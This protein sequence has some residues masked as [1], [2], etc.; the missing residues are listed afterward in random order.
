MRSAG[1][2][3][4]VWLALFWTALGVGEMRAEGGLTA[5][6]WGRDDSGQLGLGTKVVFETPTV[7]PQTGALAGKTIIKTVA[8]DRH[9]LALTADQKVFA[10]GDNQGGQL[11]NPDLLPSSVPTEVPFPE[12]LVGKTVIDLAVTLSASFLLTADFELWGWGGMAFGVAINRPQATPQRIDGGVLSGKSVVKIACGAAH[13]LALTADGMVAGV[14]VNSSGQ[15]GDGTTTQRFVPV[16]IVDANQVLG[17]R[18]VVDL[19]AASASSMLRTSDGALFAWGS[20]P[21]GQLGVGDRVNRLVPT[22]VEGSLVGRVVSSVAQSGTDGYAITTDNQLH[23]W[24]SHMGIALVA[25]TEGP[26]DRTRPN[27]AVMEPFESETLVE[28]ASGTQSGAVRTASG[29]IFTW[30]LR[31]NGRLGR[32]H[33]TGVSAPAGPVNLEDLGGDVMATSLI[34]GRGDRFSAVLADGRL[35]HWGNGSQGVVGDGG[36]YWRESPVT[37]PVSALP[38]NEGWSLLAASGRMSVGVSPGGKVYSWGAGNLGHREPSEIVPEPQRVYDEGGLDD[39]VVT[40]VAVSGSHTVV[41]SQDGDLYTWGT[42]S[43]G[44]LGDGVFHQSTQNRPRKVL[45]EGTPIAEKTITQIAAGRVHTMALS[46]DGRLFAWGQNSSGQLGDGSS[47]DRNRPT[48]VVMNGALAGKTVVAIATRN[49]TS[50]ALTADGLVFSWGSGLSGLYG[51]GE[52]SSSWRFEPQMIKMDG[53]MAGKTIVHIA[54]G[55]V[56]AY[57]IASDGTLF[58]WGSHTGGLLG[59]DVSSVGVSD[60]PVVISL[61]AEHA[62]RVPVAVTANAGTLFVLTRDGMLFSAGRSRFGALGVGALEPQIRQVLRPVQGTRWAPGFRVLSVSTAGS[63]G[64]VLALAEPKLPELQVE[65]PVGSMWP[66]VSGQVR[67]APIEPGSTDHQVLR[68]H[69]TADADLTGVAASIESSTGAFSLVGPLPSTVPAREALDVELAFSADTPGPH[70]GRLTLLTDSADL[71]PVEVA[72]TGYVLGPVPLLVT[73]PQAKIVGEGT[74]VSLAV[75]A[76]GLPPLTYQWRYRGKDLPGSTSVMLE[77][78]AVSLAQAGDYSVVVK[79]GES[80][81]SLPAHLAVVRFQNETRVLKAGTSA[82]FTLKAA[83]SDLTYQWH[84]NGLP[85]PTDARLRGI[86]SPTLRIYPLAADETWLGPEHGGDYT[87]LI[88]RSGAQP[89]SAGTLRLSVT[90]LRPRFLEPISLP[91]AAIGVD[92][93]FTVPMDPNPRRAVTRFS[94]KGL[95]AGLTINPQTGVISGRPRQ[96]RGGGFPVL[97]IAENREGRVSLPTLLQVRPLPAGTAG[98]F[99]AVLAPSEPLNQRLGGRMDLNIAESG[100]LSG[101]LQVGTQRYRLRGSVQATLASNIVSAAISIPRRNR[102]PLSLAFAIGDGE[103]DSLAGQLQDP[104]VIAASADLTG[105]HLPWSKKLPATA[106]TGLHNLLLAPP[107]S[108]TETPALPRGQGFASFTPSRTGKTRLIGK[109]ADGQSFAISS[110]V[111]A[112][113]QVAVHQLLYRGPWRGSLSGRLDVSSGAPQP[114]PLGNQINGTLLW[115]RPADTTGRSLLYPSGFRR[116]ELQVVGSGYAALSHAVLLDLVEPDTEAQLEFQA[117]KLADLPT[118][119]AISVRLLPRNGVVLPQDNPTRTTLRT[120][121]L[122]GTFSGEFRVVDGVEQR[123]ARFE[124]RV[125]HGLDGPYGAG[126]FLLPELG[127]LRPLILSGEVSLR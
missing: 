53:A 49:D 76:L 39:E 72:L 4:V 11:G 78:Q 120:N 55:T 30:G 93:S 54:A 8:G 24:G 118:S 25:A 86:N 84:K 20:N 69:Y 46:A 87:C 7:L 106:Y 26:I 61:P 79:S 80:V 127:V 109:L 114:A 6:G 88:S 37:L 33:V 77:L 81:E 32:P 98:A 89:Y 105:W 83:G 47:M 2:V 56:T 82:T 67:F 18:T 107:Q 27:L 102:S 103:P 91:S 13:L 99:A 64:H 73:Q 10:W 71:P 36:V 95:P 23:C 66:T 74:T 44:Q 100:S 40:A 34:G 75:E 58:G 19:V 116:H 90:D 28:V 101:S 59:E 12:E 115:N 16:E 41:L 125:I 63:E 111:G 119:P 15:L 94:A 29:G 35:V 104:E 113:G 57:A 22:R 112:R 9:V 122:K 52:A 85:L 70:H 126:F 38:A 62:H 5:L 42:G 110:A 92:Y 17:G 97:L 43:S 96:S 108:E 14:G 3:L 45:T 124:G 121:V 21:N 117:A 123:Q 48:A 31:L 1:G 68:L 60:Q 51:A 65:H 50:F